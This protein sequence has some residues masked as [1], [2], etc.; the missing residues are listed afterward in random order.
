MP[1]RI[2]EVIKKE[3]SASLKKIVIEL[4]TDITNK[5]GYELLELT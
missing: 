5:R 3:W 2:S 1:K 4:R